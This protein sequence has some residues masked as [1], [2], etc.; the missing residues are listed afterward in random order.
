MFGP[1]REK[2]YE[3]LAVGKAPQID[4]V[5]TPKLLSL[6]VAEPCWFSI[7]NF[8]SCDGFLGGLA[9]AA[10]LLV[11]EDWLDSDVTSQNRGHWHLP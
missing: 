4:R 8:V 6:G 11:Q 10:T 1:E 5:S 7:C 9:E 3:G 2:F